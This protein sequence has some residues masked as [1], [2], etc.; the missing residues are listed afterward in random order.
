MRISDWSSDV[1][2]SDLQCPGRRTKVLQCAFRHTQV[3]EVFRN[4]IGL[5]PFFQY[6]ENPIR[7]FQ[8]VKRAS[9]QVAVYQQFPIKAFADF[10]AVEWCFFA[11]ESN[12]FRK[13]WRVPSVFPGSGLRFGTSLCGAA[14][15]MVASAPSAPNIPGPTCIAER[16][17]RLP[18]K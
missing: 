3:F 15:M 7:Q 17:Q 8:H 18:V 9:M 5:Q 16:N 6:W 11:G 1:C 14:Y 4:S 2:S 13:R 10:P 12:G